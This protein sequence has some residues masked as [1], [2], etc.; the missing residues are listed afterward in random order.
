MP[1][2][3]FK[4]KEPDFVLS[5]KEP[6]IETKQLPPIMQINERQNDDVKQTSETAAARMLLERPI[7]EQV[8]PDLQQAGFGQLAKEQDIFY[9]HYPQYNQGLPQFLSN[10]LFHHHQAHHHHRGEGLFVV[11]LIIFDF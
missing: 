4:A 11:E 3:V 1:A 2:P 9:D 5:Y 8:T 10:N 6:D 7:Y